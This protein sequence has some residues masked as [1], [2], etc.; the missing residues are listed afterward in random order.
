MRFSLIKIETAIVPTG[1]NTCTALYAV[2]GSSQK[3]LL[4]Q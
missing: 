1:D 4:T 3:L 2:P